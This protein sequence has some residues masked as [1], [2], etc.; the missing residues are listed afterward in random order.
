M[1]IRLH[2]REHIH[3]REWIVVSAGSAGGSAGAGAGRRVLADITNKANKEVKY[4]RKAQG[5]CA[6]MGSAGMFIIGQRSSVT[7]IS[8]GSDPLTGKACAKQ[9]SGLLATDYCCFW[10]GGTPGPIRTRAAAFLVRGSE[11]KW[12]QFW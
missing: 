7:F 10:K 6:F 5:K 12:S 11:D 2:T 9:R 1:L 3:W 4:A 8:A